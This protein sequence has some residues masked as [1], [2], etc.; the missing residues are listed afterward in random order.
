M[1]EAQKRPLFYGLFHIFAN[2]PIFQK[3][4]RQTFFDKGSIH[5]KS[6]LT[7]EN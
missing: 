5:V 4:H 3:N 6:A 1:H 2:T 7:F